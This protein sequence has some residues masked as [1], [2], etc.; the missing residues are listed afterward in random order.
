MKIN[1]LI[2]LLV[3]V[4]FM[5]VFNSCGGEKI[6]EDL[7]I[8]GNGVLESGEEC[9]D[10][11]ESKNCDD[12][13][14]LAECGDKKRNA[15]AGEACDDG[16]TN[17][18][19]GCRVNCTLSTCGDGIVQIDHED[20]DHSGE[21]QECD[22]DCTFVSCGDG[23]FNATAGEE[24]DDGNTDDT[25]ACLTDCTLATCGDGLVQTGVEECDDAN[26]DSSDDCTDLCKFAVCGDGYL[27]VGV[28]ACDAAGESPTCNADCS[29]AKC[30]DGVVNASAGEE[31]DDANANG[32]DGCNNTC[33]A[34]LSA[35]FE[36]SPNLSIPDDAYNGAFDPA[37]MACATVN[38]TDDGF[39]IVK[40]IEV[41]VG[42]DHTWVDDLVIKLKGPEGD[43]LTL[44]NRPTYAE[45]ADD[46]NGCCGKG[47]NLSS[48]LPLT[49]R[50]NGANN[51]EM[52][53][54][55]LTSAQIIC[56]DENPP[57]SQCSFKP[58]PGKGPGVNFGDFFGKS[59]VGD[60]TLCVGDAGPGDAGT[61]KYFKLNLLKQK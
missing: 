26:P 61:L 15:K 18:F 25:D 33:K 47:P 29:A 23:Y 2:I 35:S 53:G 1:R 16:N 57:L 50:D 34:Q 41:I 48:S 21:T 55:T 12:D 10:G 8:C 60:W 43:I 42:I 20:C 14:T 3:A 24:C 52:M 46:G 9:D 22:G 40:D 51:A 58:S 19:D 4:G 39:N 28:E 6:I 32:N 30:G 36:I 7:P 27:H 31:C 17:E 44:A 45:A 59:S 13:C 56:K 54:N 38:S 49:F 5:K 11:V 37:K